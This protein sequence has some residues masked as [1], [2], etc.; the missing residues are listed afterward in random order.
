[1][2]S[3]QIAL[4]AQVQAVQLAQYPDLIEAVNKRDARQVSQ[5]VQALQSVTDADFIT[6]S[7]RQGIR[8]AHPITARIGLPVMGDDIRPALDEG[9]AYLSYS[10]G[11]M[12]P[13][14][15]YI[16]PIRAANGDVI[17][18][19]KVG[20]LLDTVA[21]WQN[22]KL[23]PL[24]LVAGIT[25]LLATLISTAFARLV[26]RQMQDREPWQLAQSLMTYEGVI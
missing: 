25:L 14:L 7:D 4:R 23:Q 15:R 9:K 1:L 12:G 18:M 17:G 24:L 21:V 8:L 19:I 10:V 6:V 2:M 20:Y 5:L 3:H 26:R 13:S 22:E 11:S 16:S